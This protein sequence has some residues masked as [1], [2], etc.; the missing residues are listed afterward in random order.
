ML[1]RITLKNQFYIE[2][3]IV[4]HPPQPVSLAFEAS[5]SKTKDKK[6]FT[7]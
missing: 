1:V 4:G 6:G 2:R 7:V 3:V 5:G